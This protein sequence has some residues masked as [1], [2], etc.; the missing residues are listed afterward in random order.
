MRQTTKRRLAYVV[1]AAVAVGV[2]IPQMRQDDKKAPEHTS[3][4]AT[5]S[6]YETPEPGFVTPSPTVSAIP[7]TT[8]PPSPAVSDPGVFTPVSFTPDPA[9]PVFALGITVV[10]AFNRDLAAGAETAVRVNADFVARVQ[11]HKLIV[12]IHGGGTPGGSY[13]ISLD[14][15]PSVSSDT[16]SADLTYQIH[17]SAAETHGH[18]PEGDSIEH[19]S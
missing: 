4:V 9:A 19:V 7:E 14:A 11:G 17:Q 6:S 10:I 16:Y 1:M 15:V 8:V 18:S 2:A 3:A 12:T 5:T 13:T